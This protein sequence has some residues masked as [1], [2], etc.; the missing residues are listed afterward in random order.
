MVLVT[1][2]SSVL[3]LIPRSSF[4]FRAIVLEVHLEQNHLRKKRRLKNAEKKRS[5][6]VF[7]K[8]YQGKQYPCISTCL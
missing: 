8:L 2:M 1:G 3:Y 4:F 7:P 5:I 6:T